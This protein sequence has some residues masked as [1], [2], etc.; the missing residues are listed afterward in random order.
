MAIDLFGEVPRRARRVLM[1]VIDAGENSGDPGYQVVAR[2]KCGKC[3]AETDWLQVENVSKAKSGLPC[4]ACNPPEVLSQ[5]AN[6]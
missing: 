6:A 5:H 3:G 1:H 2:F 4:E